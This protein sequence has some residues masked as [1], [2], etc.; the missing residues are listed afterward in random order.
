MVLTSI[1]LLFADETNC[2]KT[3]TV[4]N[5]S[6]DL[7]K[8]VDNLDGWIINSDLLFS[9]SKILFMSFKPHLQTSYSIGNNV[10]S[11]GTTHRDL[12]IIISSDL[13]LGPHHQHIISK[14][15]QMLG[16]LRHSFSTNITA[17]SKKHLYISLV[18]SQLMFLFNTMET[19]FIKRYQTTS[20]VAQR[21]TY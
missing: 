8:D 9:L 15:Y 4:K 1:L 13:D 5:D 18:R 6:L 11:K 16:L 12:G 14:A 21:S 17:I 10:I 7:Q 2:F 19:I 3:I 20:S